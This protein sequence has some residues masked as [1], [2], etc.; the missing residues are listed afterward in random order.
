MSIENHTVS[1]KII[2]RFENFNKALESLSVIKKGRGFSELEKTGLIM[3]F[4]FTLEMSWK[5]LQ[6]VLEFEGNDIKGVK[7]VVRISLQRGFI[8][9]GEIWM[10][11]IDKRNIMAHQYDEDKSSKIFLRVKNF[12]VTE[13]Y[14]LRKFI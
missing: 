5:L 13:I 11:M 8:T 4:I 9:N 7:D 10:E 6:D 12:Y 1:Q 14:N 2:D 3:R